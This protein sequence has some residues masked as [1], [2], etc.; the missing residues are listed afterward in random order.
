MAQSR[1]RPRKYTQR[2]ANIRKGLYIMPETIT[3]LNVYKELIGASSQDAAITTAL[4]K[5]G[6][7]SVE[8]LAQLVEVVQP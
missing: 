2:A 6:A 3:R 7:P 4:D 1:G 5:A 8:A